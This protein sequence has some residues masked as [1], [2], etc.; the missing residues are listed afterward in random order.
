MTFYINRASSATK[1]INSSISTIPWEECF[2]VYTEAA[3]TAVEQALAD[4]R[5]A[6]DLAY[7]QRRRDAIQAAGI[8]ETEASYEGDLN[9]EYTPPEL[10][11]EAKTK[12]RHK[13]GNEAIAE[14]FI[15]P[16]QLKS[17]GIRVLD[18]ILADYSKHKLNSLGSG[19]TIS[20]V[21]YLQENLDPK[22]ERDMGIYR[23]LMLDSRSEYLEKMGSGEAKKYCSF[24]PLIL[25]A[26]KLYN[27][28]DYNKWERETLNYVVNPLLREAMLTQ[29]P[30]VS[31]ERLL[32]LRDLGLIQAGKARP[33]TAYGLNKLGNTEL[34][35]VNKLV[36]MMLCQTWAAHPTN[37]TKYMVLDPMNWDTMPPSIAG[38]DIFKKQPELLKPSNLNKSKDDSP[39]DA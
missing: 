12:L 10:S 15:K 39:W 20:G 5:H 24:V 16:Y 4:A 2:R 18:Q 32:E 13:R 19:G 28:V 3:D 8:D 25:Y 29:V 35:E 26:H 31:V 23:F 22:S 38:V 33:P 11:T 14:Y 30:E 21:K 9:L 1:I 34:G 36:Q 17:W 37:R 7:A 6:Y 27:G